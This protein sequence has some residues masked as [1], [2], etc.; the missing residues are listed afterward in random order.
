MFLAINIFTACTS[1]RTIFNR[2]V[3]VRFG[4]NQPQT[5][6]ITP[7][8]LEK[9]PIPVAKYLEHCGWLGKEIP[10]NF[11]LKFTGDFSLK[12]GKYSKV[13]AEQ[14]NWIDENP[15]RLFHIHN[16]MIGGR[17]CYDKRGAFM[18][19]KLFGRFKI[20][21]AK[22]EIMNQSELVTYLNDLCIIAPGALIEAPIKWETID[23][24]TVKA[25]ISQF[26]HSVSAEIYFNENNELINFIS[27]DRYASS[28][29]VKSELLPWSTPM[30][31]YKEINGILLPSFGVAIW[32][33]TDREYVY[34]K[35]DVKDVKWNLLQP[36]K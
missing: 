4:Q 25:T 10:R 21:D 9:L 5:R 15:M 16:W 29:G 6:V 19:I 3:K 27:H 12:E 17:H 20:V 24:H 1:T 34:A 7:T 18:L 26:G 30:S 8:D 32:H 35:F 2:E 22:G 13:K 31:N 14:Y 36:K 28:D 33:Y 11:Y 23:E